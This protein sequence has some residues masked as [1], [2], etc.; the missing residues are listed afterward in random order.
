[1]WFSSRRRCCRPVV[2]GAS[3]TCFGRTSAR[4]LGAATL[5]VVAALTL[6]IP[7]Q[8]QVGRFRPG[9]ASVPPRAAVAPGANSPFR[10]A[11]NT[12][13]VANRDPIVSPTGMTLGQWSRNV[14][15]VGDALGHLPGLR[16]GDPPW[17]RPAGPPFAAA[18]MTSDVGAGLGGLWNNPYYNPF[19]L[20]SL[21]LSGENQTE[22]GGYLRGSADVINRQGEFLV[23]Y[24]K[25]RLISEDV[26]HEQLENRRRALDLWLYGR[27]RTPTAQ[28]ERERLQEIEARRAV[29]DPPS[30]E[31]YSAKSLNDLLDDVQ[32]LHARGAHG[33]EVGLLD[34]VVRRINLA[35]G[36]GGGNFGLL[37]NDGRLRWPLALT[38]PEFETGR[39]LVHALTSDAVRQAKN[40]TLD[41]ATLK[42][43]S[44]GVTALRFQLTLSIKDIPPDQYCEAKRY[45]VHLTDAVTALRQPNV[46][47]SVQPTQAQ[48][49][50]ELV[51]HMTERGLRF[52]PA[53][54]GDETAYLALHRALAAY[55]VGARYVL[56]RK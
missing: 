12:Q 11:A 35:S 13:G 48:T 21:S 31:I 25:A 4:H 17:L 39:E 20:Q 19:G 28:D 24:Q 53:V 22:F 54:A 26:R 33:P 3:E 44:R 10:I 43:M 37:K 6:A 7:G 16:P 14:A 41:P 29:T 23:N 27:E 50:E 49:V 52:A 8:A 30:T 51:K 47:E 5:A 38:G 15:T 42:D 45:L 1:M 40:G 56:S 36:Q 46:A 9:P 32:K 18:G 55:D 2:S 34:S